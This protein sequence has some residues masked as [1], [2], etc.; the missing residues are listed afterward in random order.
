MGDLFFSAIEDEIVFRL[1]KRDDLKASGQTALWTKLAYV[2]VSTW[3]RHVE[4]EKRVDFNTVNA[5][6]VYTLAN[7]GASDLRAIISMRNNTT[8]RRLAHSD[9]I[10]NDGITESSGS[11]VVRYARY[12]DAVELDPTPNNVQS[13]RL[14]Y[15]KRVAALTNFAT[16][17]SE[18]SADFDNFIICRGVWIARGALGETERASL[19][20]AEFQDLVRMYD[21]P[22]SEEEER[23][24]D[25]ALAPAPHLY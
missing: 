5:Q 22:I 24:D 11:A 9:V 25:Y 23:D 12:A 3:W 14:R 13:I 7:M 19:A 2:D 6:R 18:L 21:W 10:R 1:G 17:K 8:P 4:L 16:Q 15:R 20:K